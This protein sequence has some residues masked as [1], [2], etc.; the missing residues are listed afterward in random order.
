M[1]QY[2]DYGT[3]PQT[4]RDIVANKCKLLDEYIILQTGNYEYT[5]LIHNLV[6]DEVTQL[7]F[8]RTN[9]YSQ[10]TVDQRAGT[11]EFTVYNEYYCYSN[12]GLGAALDL[13]VMDAVVAHAA[14]VMTVTLM[15]LIVF[16]S[17][18]FPFRKKK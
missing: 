1:I 9:N 5:A 8:T 11:W 15:F 12:V 4:V 3:I 18:L 13:P 14:V 17:T 7:T 6:T 2:M 10:Y 16:K